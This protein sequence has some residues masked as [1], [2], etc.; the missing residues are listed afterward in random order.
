VA[1]DIVWLPEAWICLWI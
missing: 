1:K